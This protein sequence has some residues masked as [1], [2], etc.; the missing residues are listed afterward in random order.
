MF[1]DGFIC[2]IPIY[3]FPILPTALKHHKAPGKSSAKARSA[4]L[5][6]HFPPTSE[7]SAAH[8]LR[9][10]LV[11][12]GRLFLGVPR[13][14]AFGA[15]RPSTDLGEISGADFWGWLGKW[16]ILSLSLFGS[17]VYDFMTENGYLSPESCFATSFWARQLFLCAGIHGLEVEEIGCLLVLHS[18][19]PCS[20]TGIGA[21]KCVECGG[22]ECAVM[23][24]EENTVHE[25]L[26][27]E[28]DSPWF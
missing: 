22:G 28:D 11:R 8:R 2:K 12:Q 6:D 19:D 21:R 17:W 23:I 4:R 9:P 26:R 16:V 24:L 18:F 13:H 3:P 10:V 25:T 5:E 20:I 27:I 14:V 1:V 7:C 15:A